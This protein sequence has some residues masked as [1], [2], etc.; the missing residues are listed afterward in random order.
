MRDHLGHASEALDCE[1]W[2]S[3][4]ASFPQAPL[5]H[6]MAGKRRG[7]DDMV[8]RFHRL[9]CQLAADERMLAPENTDIMF[10]KQIAVRCRREHVPQSALRWSARACCN[11]VLLFISRAAW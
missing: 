4:Q 6:V 7:D 2:L 3:R 1:A 9:E 10:A 5:N 11:P 8:K